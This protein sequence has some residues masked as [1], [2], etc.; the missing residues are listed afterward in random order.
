MIDT[1]KYRL[2][3]YNSG[4]DYR[5]QVPCCLENICE[6]RKDNQIFITGNLGNL[7][8]KINQNTIRVENS[9]CKWYLGD[10]LQTLTW[11][12]VKLANEK[13]S[14]ILHVNM[15]HA[16]VVRLD[17]GHNFKM[18]HRIKTYFES[19]GHMPR[20]KRLEQPNGICFRTGS[21]ELLFYDKL[22]EQKLNSVEIPN[23]FL[24]GNLL[25]Y[26]LKILCNI[27]SI[28]NRSDF[29]VSHLS[30]FEVHNDLLQLYKNKFM[31]I[32][33]KK[34]LNLGYDLAKGVKGL[35]DIASAYFISVFGV[36]TVLNQIKNDFTKGKLTE[37]EKRGM[38][39]VVKRLSIDHRYMIESECSKELSCAVGNYCFN[40]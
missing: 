33:M 2:S 13:L 11:G 7:K 29:K 26:E 9:L 18:N 21:L 16:D 36:E 37:K 28:L 15:Q 34:E 20:Y 4:T 39:D 3:D 31:K 8:V 38:L 40:L 10:N 5:A 30:D 25:R 32:N 14:D 12:D 23:E 1:I 35:K 19:L 24:C 17:I 6:S 27:K 22:K